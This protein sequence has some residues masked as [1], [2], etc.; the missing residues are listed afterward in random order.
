VSFQ[1]KAIIVISPKK[2][3]PLSQI[4]EE[5]N[6]RRAMSMD[7]APPQQLYL[8]GPLSV[9]NSG[10]WKKARTLAILILAMHALFTSTPCF[11]SLRQIALVYDGDGA[12]KEGCWQSAALM[13]E[14]LGF[15]VRFINATTWSEEKFQDAALWIHPG[16]KSATAAATMTADQKLR[17]RKFVA[18]GGGYVGFCAG[19]FIASAGI[20]KAK[21]DVLKLVETFQ[22][23]PLVA[24]LYPEKRA[25]ALIFPIHWMGSDRYLYWEGGPYFEI[26][27]DTPSAVEIIARY[28]SGEPVTV[29]NHYGK[30]RVYVTGLHPEAPE[31]WRTYFKLSDPDGLDYILT[32]QMI[33]WVTE[34]SN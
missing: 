24:T 16:G 30:G 32:E 18:D 3:V 17:L 10:S 20:R 31:A 29:R 28:P 23:V 15:T 19:A 14:R 13:A 34:Q 26:E 9:F 7:S 21:G 12:C 2:M 5:S 27:K 8:Q 33:H 25:E 1:N 6:Q 22:L 11:A 4:P